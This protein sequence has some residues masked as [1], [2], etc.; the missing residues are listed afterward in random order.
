MKSVPPPLHLRWPCVSLASGLSFV[1]CE[2]NRG[3]RPRCV[4][5]QDKGNEITVESDSR[6][7]P[8]GSLDLVHDESLAQ[9]LPEEQLAEEEALEA[10]DTELARCLALEEAAKVGL[11]RGSRVEDLERLQ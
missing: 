11:D 8:G 7:N 1:V 10:A 2:G 5:A 6:S 9:R 4:S 3:F